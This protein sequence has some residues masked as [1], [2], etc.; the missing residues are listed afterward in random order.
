MSK[1]YLKFPFS[2]KQLIFYQMLENCNSFLYLLGVCRGEEI[3]SSFD[4][5]SSTVFLVSVSSSV[6]TACNRLE[7]IIIFPTCCRAILRLASIRR[8]TRCLALIY[9]TSRSLALI[10]RAILCLA[11][12]T[13]TSP[14]RR[15]FAS[16]VLNCKSQNKPYK[17]LGN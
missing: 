14:T 1:N 2:S 8:P 6:P 12:S 3:I 11:A 9:R 13:S 16:I 17:G 10:Y 5:R 15:R 7:A 4:L